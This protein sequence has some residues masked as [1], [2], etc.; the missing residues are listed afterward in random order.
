MQ[1]YHVILTVALSFPAWTY[2][3]V[4]NVSLGPEHQA[5]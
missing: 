2:L 3:T 4:C 1:H 5:V